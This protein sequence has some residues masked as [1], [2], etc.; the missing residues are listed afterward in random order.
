MGG[1][2]EAMSKVSLLHPTGDDL[3]SC[4]VRLGHARSALTTIKKWN[5]YHRAL[6][7]H[8]RA[9]M[10]AAIATLDAIA[11]APEGGDKAA[12]MKA[13]IS[14]LRNFDVTSQPNMPLI[15]GRNLREKR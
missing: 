11:E 1:E 8:Y 4:K 7:H 6:V 15:G 2:G 12:A 10:D 13:V 5:R 9:H 3:A 14:N